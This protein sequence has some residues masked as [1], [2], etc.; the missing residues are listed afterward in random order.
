MNIEQFLPFDLSVDD[1]IAL[2]AAGAAF[3]CVLAVWSATVQHDPVGVRAKRLRQR[4]EELKASWTAPKKNAVTRK[5][6]A[7][8]LMRMLS[9]RINLVKNKTAGKMTDRLMQAGWRSR[10]AVIIFMFAKL[11]LPFLFGG[12]AFLLLDVLKVVA[13]SPMREQLALLG[14]VIAGGYAPDLFLK[15][16]ITKRHQMIQKSLPDCLDLLVI[17]AEAG[18]SLDAA[19]TRVSSE[20][21]RAAPQLAEEFGLTGVELGF[22]PERRMALENLAKRC[23]LPSIRGVVSTLIQTEKYGTPVANSLRVL[24]AEFRNDRML[25][26]EEKAAKLP[27]ILTVPMVLFIVPSLFIVLL[28]P[29]ILRTLDAIDGKG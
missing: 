2:M 11:A 7:M 10:D 8:T 19:L 12:L 22:L 14:A 15:N 16:M 21:E 4:H 18:L 13:L 17:C 3:A 26:A 9:Q 5:E 6:S 20:M 23:D 27:V 25:K 24:A 1:A 28:G 29:A